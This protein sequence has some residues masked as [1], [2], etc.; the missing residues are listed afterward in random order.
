MINFSLVATPAST[1]SIDQLWTAAVP[2]VL[3]VLAECG[4]VGHEVGVHAAYDHGLTKRYRIEHGPGMLTAKNDGVNGSIQFILAG[5]KFG[6][7]RAGQAS[8]PLVW[9]RLVQLGFEFG[10]LHKVL[11]RVFDPD[12]VAGSPGGQ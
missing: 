7:A 12:V 5:D 10:E 2:K 11:P 1:I 6:M 8:D 4:Y 3:T 9:M